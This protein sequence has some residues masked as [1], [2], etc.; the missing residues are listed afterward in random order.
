MVE[1]ERDRM[2][3]KRVGGWAWRK[4]LEGSSIGVRLRRPNLESFHSKAALRRV[5]LVGDKYTPPCI[6]T[7]SLRFYMHFLLPIYYLVTLPWLGD[8]S[9]QTSSWLGV[10]RTA[11]REGNTR[12]HASKSLYSNMRPQGDGEPARP[13]AF[14]LLRCFRVNSK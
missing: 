12:R 2:D 4:E 10:K 6:A 8:P 1:N 11:I 14:N 7:H 9:L 5:L 3:S 13:A